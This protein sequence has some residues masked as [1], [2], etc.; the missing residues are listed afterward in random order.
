VKTATPRARSQECEA[1][2][3]RTAPGA[4]DEEVTTT[5]QEP[6]VEAPD[7]GGRSRDRDVKTA[8][9]RWS[10]RP[11]RYDREPK[12][13][14]PRTRRQDHDQEI[15]AN[16]LAVR[17]AMTWLQNRQVNSNARSHA[18]A[19][20]VVLLQGRE[21]AR[22]GI[23]LL[24]DPEP[25][26]V[27]PALPQAREPICFALWLSGTTGICRAYNHNVKSRSRRQAHQMQTA[28]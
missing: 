6:A 17:D 12:I 16:G 3:R 21:P 8:T 19:F 5:C 1:K 9:Q 28:N 10:A 4:Q 11:I 15:E 20:G 14:T 18:P 24:Q 22:F 13:T 23:V 26:F 2:T 25:A 27:A 7:S